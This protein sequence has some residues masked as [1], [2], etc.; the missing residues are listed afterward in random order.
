MNSIKK[1]KNDANNEDEN[2]KI[3]L[4][5]GN[6]MLSIQDLIN[7]INSLYSRKKQYNKI[8]PIEQLMKKLTKNLDDFLNYIYNNGKSEIF[9]NKR[10]SSKYFAKFERKINYINKYFF[11]EERNFENLRYKFIDIYNLSKYWIAI[12]SILLLKIFINNKEHVLIKKYFKVIFLFRYLEIFSLNICKLILDIYINTIKDLIIINENNISFI[13]DLIE[14]LVEFLK[15]NQKE[16][17]NILYFIISIFEEYISS[18][19]NL[20]L[21]FQSSP[22]FFKFLNYQSSEDKYENDVMLIS[23]LSNIYKNNITSNFLF[24]EIYKNGILNLHYY[25][26]SMSLLSNIINQEFFDRKFNSNFIIKK[27]FLIHKNTPIIQQKI[28][29]KEEEFSIIFSFKL[30]DES[31][32]IIIFSFYETSGKNKGKLY[33]SLNIYKNNDNYLLKIIYDKEEWPIND[34]PIL[35]GN[36]Y[37]ICIS[38]SNIPNKKNVELVLY[39]NDID[40]KKDNININNKESNKINYKQ[41]TKQFQLKKIGEV[42]LKLGEKNFEGIIGDFLIINK[43]LNDKDISYL[44]KL[45]SCY[46]YIAESFRFNSDLINIPD[47]LYSNKNE[48]I[49]HFKKQKFNYLL[50]L[51]SDKSNLNYLSHNKIYNKIVGLINYNELQKIETFKLSNTLKIFIDGN[52]IEFLVFQLHNLFSIFD[53]SDITYNEIY[54][55]NL[56]LFQALKLYYDIIVIISH[57]RKYNFSLNKFVK[58]DYFFLSFLIILDYYKKINKYLK[59]DLNI[60]NLLLDYVSF[61]DNNKYF[62][63]RNLILSIL[64]DET[65]F[66]QKKVIKECKILENLD[67]IF[68]HLDEEDEDLFDIEIL[69]KILNH[70]FILQS[71]EIDHKYYMK[72]ILDLIFINNKKIVTNIFKYIIELKSEDILYHYLKT[73]YLKY[74]QL[75]SIFETNNIHKEFCEFIINYLN[76]DSHNKNKYFYKI[77]ALISLLGD[78][79]NIKSNIY[80]NIQKMENKNISS[81]LIIHRYYEIKSDFINCFDLTKDKKL[82]FVK[83]EEKMRSNDIIDNEIKDNQIQE[84]DKKNKPSIIP[85]N[86]DLIKKINREKFLLKFDLIIKN[87]NYIF[88]IYLPNK[89]NI[90]NN[91]QKKIILN[92]FEIIKKFFEEL[93]EA[94]N[95]N[96]PEKKIFYDLFKKLKETKCF[97][98]NYLLLDYNN[99][100]E[101]LKNMIKLSLSKIDIPFYFDY[102]HSKEIID[103]DNLFNNQKIKNA[104]TKIILTE[105]SNI[106]KYES[107]ININ[108]E[109]LLIIIYRKY[110]IKDKISEEEEKFIIGF[111]L[112]LSIK[113]LFQYNYFY[114]IEGDYYNFFELQINIL[115]EIYKMHDYAEQYMNL[116]FGFILP[117][118]NEAHFYLSD[119]KLLKNEKNIGDTS[120]NL[121]DKFGDRI[122]V[123][124]LLYS[125]YFLIYFLSIKIDNK[126]EKNQ[127][128]DNNA[129]FI[130]TIIDVIFNNCINV[131]K[132]IIQ[133][134]LTKKYIIKESIAKF[135][136]YNSMYNYFISNV[137]KKFTIKEFEE[138]FKK[139][140]EVMKNKKEREKENLNNHIKS[141]SN[142]SLNKEINKDI[143]K[144]NKIYYSDSKLSSVKESNEDNNSNDGKK[145]NDFESL[146]EKNVIKL[147]EIN[148]IQEINLE[149]KNNNEEKKIFNVK[150]YLNNKNIPVIYFNKL[151]DS[152][153]NSLTKILLNPKA[154]F[155][156]KTFIFSLKDMI[157][158]NKNFVKLSKAFKAFSKRFVLETSSKEEDLFHLNYP[159][160]IKNFICNDYYRPFLK[161]DIKFF[162]RDLIKISHNYISP[163]IFEKIRKKFDFNNI[164]FIEFFP[165]NIIN[166]HQEENQSVLCE[167]I[168]YRGSI[169]GNIYLK[170]M[171]LIFK[172]EHLTILDKSL[173]DPLFF[174]F[175]FQNIFKNVKIS[176]KIIMIYY[177]E[178]REIIMKRFHLKRI[179]Y[180]IILKNGRS[181]LFNF[182][183]SDNFNKFQSIIAKKGVAI[184]NDPVKLFEKKDYKNKFKKGEISNFQYLLLLNKFSARTYNDINQY[185]IFPLLYINFEKNIKRDLSKAICLNKDKDNLDLNKHIDNFKIIGYY[186]NN[187]YST[188]AYILYYL[189]RE[190]PYT[191]LQIEF[192]SAKFD[193]PER[194]F[195]NYNSYSSGILGSSE[196]RELIPELFYNFEICLNLNHNNFG[197]MN[198]SKD[199][200]NNFNSNK[201]KTSVEFI[202]NHRIILENTNIVPWI[203][204]IFGY[205]QLNDSKELMN[206]F[207]LSSY[208]QLFDV[209]IQKMKD[210]YKDLNDS[211]IYEKIRLKLAILDIG[212]TPIQL[213]KTSHPEKIMIN[214]SDVDPLRKESSNSNNSKNSKNSTSNSSSNTDINKRE[215]EREKK[216]KNNE[217]MILKWFSPIKIFLNKTNDKKYKLF[218]NDTNM[219]LFFIF[220]DKIC[221]YN[222]YNV[223]KGDSFPKI[224]YPVEIPLHTKLINLELD[225]TDSSRN[226]IIELMPGFY[227]ICRF[228]NR[229][230]K[231]INFTQKY[232]FS[233]LWTSVITSIE[234][235]K[236][237]IDTKFLGCNYEWK[238]YFGDEE[239]YLCILKYVYEY[240]F[241]NNEIKFNKIKIIQKIKLHENCINTIRHN[242]R[243]GIVI[244]SSLNGDIAINN[245]YSLEILN[246]IKI[247]ENYL[248]NNIKISSYDLIYVGCYN[249]ENKNYYIKCYTLNGLKVTKLKSTIKIVNFFV[250]NYVN[251]LYENKLISKYLLY[252]FKKSEKSEENYHLLRKEYNSDKYI[253]KINFGDDIDDILVHCIYCHKINRIINIDNKNVLTI[254][255]LI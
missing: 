50:K 227:C 60:Y 97:I 214:N 245:A 73:I 8:I 112:S 2:I 149:N 14:G 177:K 52:G 92:I 212:I 56:F 186:F 152:K 200:I 220:E 83:N 159:T 138:H 16:D 78:D 25:S 12:D 250:N 13:D 205:N 172:D 66:N 63:Q 176:S 249:F 53:I 198:F 70:Q 90:E 39:I 76:N 228:I 45:N 59:M 217:N 124:N 211:E 65:L 238:I 166:K 82:K 216:M 221:I 156:W 123:S 234:P 145:I 81:D 174:A 109:K 58:F 91:F 46:S 36:D 171:F 67:Y 230:I 244:T 29:L 232:D 229:T 75:K 23:F 204:N 22:I 114:L 26:N 225:F 100:I 40:S 47:Y 64:L 167:N 210:K 38:K 55:F 4:N 187:H 223:I 128:Q 104:I 87:I 239:G 61:C 77:S 9:Y 37:L 243:L 141:K 79:L 28:N 202:I 118:K 175:S 43:K 62:D 148:E 41:F 121:K 101:L 127:I 131:F 10:N 157:F 184:C 226:I 116:I 155:F 51:L 74:E 48:M 135:D 151:I 80:E 179:G 119:M 113:N 206:L 33:M 7:S 224:K 153:K 6:L 105:I 240:I 170:E 255:K 169:L 236:S 103:E 24:K 180:E 85:I 5:K 142:P 190:I 251:V 117:N 31:N 182:F 120:S 218:L 68:S 44:L 94:K 197:K 21:K 254:E 71:K 173:K 144:N 189:V 209:D 99:A 11:A 164:K 188:S 160:K 150:S 54:I 88:N 154:E 86:R 136:I 231:F 126:E 147:N 195:N 248:I 27:G 178:I 191:Y 3:I 134:K 161:P 34:I 95:N 125:L 111:I 98:K 84:T 19:Y 139:N 15:R 192:Q 18:N 1:S 122:L 196:N 42:E 107:T 168:S 89:T 207:P 108:R 213:F 165:I 115:F 20:K 183:N 93:I 140:Y 219:N 35:K 252:Y 162:K 193:V 181:Y 129:D 17:K 137:K 253:N 132:N 201:Y 133:N 242:N 110:L 143:E 158:Y 235:F 32:E 222:I 30:F 96:K 237:E 246:M 247:G 194:L 199:M 215:K 72:I 49:I 241:N 102:L 233:Y 208:E 106:S 146:K 203:N 69:Y 57:D 163:K 185:L 130:N